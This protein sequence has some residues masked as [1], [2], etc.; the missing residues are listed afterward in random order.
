VPEAALVATSNQSVLRVAATCCRAA[1]SESMRSTFVVDKKDQKRAR[2]SWYHPDD[3]VSAAP[4]S[5]A[6]WHACILL[7]L[8]QPP[9]CADWLC[10]TCVA[11]G[12]TGVV[13][14]GPAGGPEVLQ[15][16]FGRGMRLGSRITPSVACTWMYMD[17]T[18]SRRMRCDAVQSHAMSA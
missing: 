12:P 3:T 7:L 10:L 17:G 11:D 13:E 14:D 9:G 2:L 8:G 15:A 1:K 5:R 16:V 18:H 4:D 6:P